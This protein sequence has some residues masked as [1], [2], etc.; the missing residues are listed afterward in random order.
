VIRTEKQILQTNDK[1]EILGF[2][3]E[4]NTTTVTPRKYGSGNTVTSTNGQSTDFDKAGDLQLKQAASI[5]GGIH[6]AGTADGSD[7][8]PLNIVSMSNN[9]IAGKNVAGAGAKGVMTAAVGKMTNPGLGIVLGMLLES[10]KTGSG[11]FNFSSTAVLV[12]DHFKTGSPIYNNGFND[13]TQIQLTPDEA[14]R[15]GSLYDDNINQHE[16]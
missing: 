6:A 5:I 3:A 1:G 14:K 12:N 11:S 8:G 9:P 7:E 16:N 2:S 13:N 15:E 10:A 4:W